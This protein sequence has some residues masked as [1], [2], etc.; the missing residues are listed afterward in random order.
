PGQVIAVAQAR[1][2]IGATTVATN[3]ACALVGRSTMFRKVERKR[4]ALLDFDLQFGNANVYLDL[5]DNQG[6]LDLMRAGEMP[7]SAFVG[8]ILQR[9]S[10]GLDLLCAPK[11]LVPLTTVRAE[12]IAALLDLLCADHDYVVVDLPRAMVDWI[13]PVLQRAARLALVTDTSVPCIRQA[14]RM[15]DFLREDFMGLPVDFIVN[16]EKKPMI[17]SDHHREAEKVLQ[18]KLTHWLPDN[19]RLARAAVDLGRPVVEMKPGSDLAKAL[20]G[21]AVSVGTAAQTARQLNA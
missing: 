2:G 14:R 16:R 21:L 13:E 6:F 12:V 3:L 9:H 19:P 7:D 10:S 4:V 18:T 1:G 17:K 8:G 15:V 5:E 11:Q 20:T